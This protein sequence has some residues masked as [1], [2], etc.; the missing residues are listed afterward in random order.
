MP[1]IIR[2]RKR[3]DRPCGGYARKSEVDRM[4][5]RTDSSR[6][7]L[8][9]V[10]I[11]LLVFLLPSKASPERFKGDVE[12]IEKLTPGE[13][14]TYFGLQYL[15]S[16]YQIRQFLS[17][18]SGI[19][20]AEWIERFWIGN[21]PTPAT[22][23]NERRIEHEKRIALARKL[24]GM[25]KAPG[26]DRRGETLIRYG[27]PGYRAKTFGDVG[28]Y[29]MIPPGEMWYYESLDMLVQ[30]HDYNLKGEFIYAIQP[31]GLT[32][33]QVLDRL[34]LVIE[35]S[36]NH[37]MAGI[38]LTPEEVGAI[39]NFNPDKIDHMADPD[40]RM[41]TPKDLIAGRDVRK[42]QRSA[43]NFYKYLKENPFIYS[44]ELDAAILPVYFD[45][46]AFRGGPGR[47]R[48]E[49]NIEVP[50]SELRFIRREG[51]L[52]AD[53]ELKVLVRDFEMNPVSSASDR[54]RASQAGETFTGP[55]HIPG[56][57]VVTLEPGY[58]RLGLEAID[59]HSGLR[60]SFRTTLRLTSFDRSLRLSDIQFAS[61]IRETEENT[62]F[63]KGNL[64]VIPHPLHAYRIP[65]PVTIYF[66]IYGLDT[67]ADGLAFYEVEYRIVPL[68][69]RRRGPVLEEAPIAIS[70]RF[71]TTGFGST[72]V[73][74]LEIATDN[75]WKGPFELIV[76]V[77]DR[78]SLLSVR[79]GARFSILE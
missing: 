48:T 37:E 66:E 35:H 77:R 3:P 26:W 58:Y 52:N 47:I 39:S 9:I 12:L 18:E 76:T 64:R 54:L 21:D 30:F 72:Q 51:R 31:Q 19:E 59:V 65:F 69:K 73:Q 22:E 14:L 28:F 57:V 11:S 45:V 46:T 53:V 27:M 43:N 49:V 60:G 4:K 62:K 8:R 23:T 1:F 75:L 24:F 70:S 34:K 33:R 63:V 20:R 2:S 61:S 32:A 6:I 71:E 68:E 10:S 29:R 38:Y 25:K 15:M 5:H 16:K 56:Q 78:R 7:L 13:R 44:F 67:D 41:A 55:S 74:R 42:M 50:T 36:V 40:I 17:L 79:E